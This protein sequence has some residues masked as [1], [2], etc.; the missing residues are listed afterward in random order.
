[1]AR[2]LGLL[3]AVA[4]CGAEQRNGTDPILFAPPP[5]KRGAEKVLV[6]INGAF[7][8]N[9]EYAGLARAVQDAAPMPL[10]VAIPR[11]ALDCPNPATI[12][13]KIEAALAAVDA[14]GFA[15]E[16][17]PAADVAVGGHSLG[18]I[19]AQTAVVAGGY[20]ALVLFGSYLQNQI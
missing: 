6:I 15:G 11:F 20:A 14:A 4:A 13:R 10:W 17:D 2:G 9:T 8:P 12:G 19:F 7:V 1:M 16:L 5:S 18:G 3:L